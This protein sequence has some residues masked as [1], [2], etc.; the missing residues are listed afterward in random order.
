VPQLAYLFERFPSFGQHFIYREVAELARQGV[1]AQLFSIRRPQD[2][3]A[4]AWDPEIVRRVC[5]LPE[6]KELVA[7]VERDIRR[8]HLPKAACDAIRTWGRQTDFL[9]LYQA[10]YVAMRLRESGV[11]HVHA[12][13]A[14]MAAR[15]AYWLREL[16]D[17][18]YS[19]TAHANDIFAP[20]DFVVSVAR[21]I[22][23]AETVVTVSDFA[24]RALQER[25]PAA[26]QKIQR[27]YNGIDVDAFPQASFDAPVP[28][29]ISVGRLIEK[30]GF[31]DLIDACAKLAR[32]G[33]AFA[34]EI[35]GEGPREQE[36]LRK[37]AE[38]GLERHVALAGS[39]PQ[40][41]IAAR[42]ASATMFVLPCRTEADGGMDN[43]PTVIMEAMAAALP[44]ISTRV[45]GVPEMVADGATGLLLFERDT[46]ALA[47]AMAR[48]LN[49]RE[50]A[51][52]FGAAGRLA[53]TEKFA[54]EKTARQLRAVLR[55]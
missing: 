10:A 40:R 8:G 22:E 45:A 42:L 36:L 52:R 12:H 18:T 32:D 34:A 16:F 29:I 4:E 49:D 37:I 6:E 48:L 51:R 31:G 47:S 3:P 55:V 35:I 24:V 50:T 44:V 17:I 14:G 23:T 30:K 46:E 43:L 20:R 7:D 2:E 26:A 11:R 39:L 15:T 13:F 5:Y 54:I 25:F 1:E 33:S 41:E 9:R 28:K 19:F 21:L 27:V 53:A 38:R